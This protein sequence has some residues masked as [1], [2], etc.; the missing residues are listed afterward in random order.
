MIAAVRAP[1]PFK[2]RR[3]APPSLAPSASAVGESSGQRIPRRA[4][5]RR[6]TIAVPGGNQEAFPTISEAMQRKASLPRHH[7]SF[8]RD[9]R[10]PQH[11]DGRRITKWD[12]AQ[13]RWRQAEEIK[14]SLFCVVADHDEELLELDRAVDELE[15]M[16]ER[17]P[18]CWL[19][20]LD[21]VWKTIYT[22]PTPNQPRCDG[23]GLQSPGSWMRWRLAFQHDVKRYSALVILLGTSGNLSQN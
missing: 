3:M 13:A 19:P 8:P 23:C 9:G 17:V 11:D 5:L 14:R 4:A 20:P 18:R 6:L 21:R 16:M 15:L 2:S 22:T 1:P 7:G 10:R 12:R